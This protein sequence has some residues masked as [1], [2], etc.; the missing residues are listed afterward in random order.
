M[1]SIKV[2]EFVPCRWASCSA[3]TH[4]NKTAPNSGMIPALLYPSLS[5]QAFYVGRERDAWNQGGDGGKLSGC[6]A[7]YPTCSDIIARNT[8][9]SQ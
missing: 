5:S 7:L 8:I 1:C 6:K 3:S 4:P 2:T 9:L